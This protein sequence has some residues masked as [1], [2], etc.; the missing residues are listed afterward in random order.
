MPPVRIVLVEPSHPGNIGAAARA[1]KTMGFES[2]YL[3]RPKRFPD[4][5]A[6]W[7]AAQA[8]DVVAGAAVV[9]SLDEAIGDCALAVGTSTR[10]RRIPWPRADAESVA[11]RL[12]GEAGDQPVAILF[13]REASGL[14]NEELQRCQ[15]HLVIPAH[16]GYPSLNLAMAVQV[17]CYELFK[18]SGGAAPPAA[19]DRRLATAAEVE[20]FLGHL[21][22]TLRRIDFLK[23]S[24][25]RQAM[26]RFRRF[27][28]RAAP[29][30]AELGMLRGMLT[31]I[32]ELAGR[33]SAGD[34]PDA[35]SQ[36]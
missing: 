1:M 14:T 16:P 32:D 11:A 29:D 33:A 31:H 24:A 5:Q 30:E 18:A 7:R 21:E 9:P 22:G 13:G 3:V 34:A 8:V 6:D 35:T 25:P 27:F 10:S 19:S 12:A 17:V 2:L 15:L 20:A 28:G 26:T 4:P 23:D 36:G